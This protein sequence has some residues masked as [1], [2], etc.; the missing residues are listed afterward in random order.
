[1]SHDEELDETPDPF[2]PVTDEDLARSRGEEVSAS[3]D[4]LAAGLD[5]IAREVEAIAREVLR[6]D[7]RLERLRI[8]VEEVAR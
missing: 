1:M 4:E 2:R 3:L 8:L 7:R 6:L 5:R